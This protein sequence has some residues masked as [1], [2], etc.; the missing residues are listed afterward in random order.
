[1][2]RISK[3]EE[4]TA[5][6]PWRSQDHPI[7]CRALILRT[8]TLV[9]L[10][11]FGQIGAPACAQ[12]EANRRQ[13]LLDRRGGNAELAR[14]LLVTLERQQEI[15]HFALGRSVRVLSCL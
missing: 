3:L 7:I 13:A 2:A 9:I 15:E 11:G 1:M 12:L 8:A 10:I 5:G 4:R 6:L 14:N